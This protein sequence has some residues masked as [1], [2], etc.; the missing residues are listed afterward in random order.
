MPSAD[1]GA[2]AIP[3]DV[4]DEGALFASDAATTGW[5]GAHQAEVRLGAVVAV[6][7]A[8]G[9]GQMAARAATLMGAERVVGID[10]VRQP[11]RAGPHAHRGGHPRLREGRGPRRAARDDGWPGPNGYRMFKNKEDGCV[12]AVF[13]TGA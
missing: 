4:C 12:R 2:F 13:R 8:G 10:P 5:T 3:D 11:A 9:V 6:W 7:G 1:Q